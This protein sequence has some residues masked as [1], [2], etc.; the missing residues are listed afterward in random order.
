MRTL[1]IGWPVSSSVGPLQFLSWVFT[2]PRP[3]SMQP[4]TRMVC[5]ICIKEGQAFCFLENIAFDV[6]PEN[7]FCMKR[8]QARKGGFHAD[9]KWRR[10]VEVIC[11]H[12]PSNFIGTFWVFQH[13]CNE[14]NCLLSTR[15]YPDCHLRPGL[16]SQIIEKRPGHSRS[17]V[18]REVEMLYQCQ[19]HRYSPTLYWNCTGDMH[20]FTG[21]IVVRQSSKCL[22]CFPPHYTIQS[23][24]PDCFS[25]G[26]THAYVSHHFGQ[27][28]LLNVKNTVIC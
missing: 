9:V 20:A 10:Q 16:F 23:D 11:Y 26:M 3:L 5:S 14:C 24:N 18:F 2:L 4:G 12:F 17:R 7:V 13:L 28:C 25:E 8:E 6:H 15:M 19:G 22:Q 21:D 27:R 1:V